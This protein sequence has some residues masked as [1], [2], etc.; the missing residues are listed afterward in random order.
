MK[1]LPKNKPQGCG[2]H[3]N[4]FLL[5]S[6]VLIGFSIVRRRSAGPMSSTRCT[7]MSGRAERP[8]KAAPKN[9][10]HYSRYIRSSRLESPFVL[11]GNLIAWRWRKRGTSR[12]NFEHD[13]DDVIR[14]KWS[15]WATNAASEP[16]PPQ[17]HGR[18]TTTCQPISTH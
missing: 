1:K 8:G 9:R 7:R 18:V 5:V 6:R 17:I 16:V 12:P 14:S 2:L 4:S 10:K 13:P 15:K 11:S 3:C